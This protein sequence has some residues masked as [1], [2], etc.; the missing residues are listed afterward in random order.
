[1]T[2]QGV[3]VKLDGDF[4]VCRIGRNSACAACGKCGMTEKQKHVDFYV[5]NTLEAKVGDKVTLDIPDANSARLAF[6]AY[7]IPLAPALA[8]L[9]ASLALWGK[10]WLAILA[11]FCGLAVGFVVVAWIDKLHKHRWTK[12]PIMQGYVE[13]DEG[14]TLDAKQSNE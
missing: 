7:C 2:E 9:F 10:D 14:E 5:E 13:V 11:F 8:A 6:F 1:M 4:A 3:V 12:C